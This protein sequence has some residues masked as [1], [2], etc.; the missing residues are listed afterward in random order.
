MK[1]LLQTLSLVIWYCLGLNPQEAKA[2]NILGGE[3]SWKY[4]SNDTFEI[5]VIVYCDDANSNIS[6]ELPG[7]SADSCPSSHIIIPDSALE[8][9]VKML[10]PIC[11]SSNWSY[12]QSLYYSSG[13]FQ[14]IQ[15][16]FRYKVY[17]HNSTNCCWYKIQWTGGT[18][19][20]S[21]TGFSNTPYS[22]DAWLNSCIKN[23]HSPEIRNLPDIF[24]AKNKTVMYS[25]EALDLDG[26]SLSY[27]LATPNGGSYTSPY[28][29]KYPLSCVGGN[30]PSVSPSVSGFNLDSI[31]GFLVF[32][33]NNS[34][35]SLYKVMISEWRKDSAGIYHIIGK[36][37]REMALVVTNFSINQVPQVNAS[38]TSFETCAGSEIC[39][40]IWTID[41]VSDQTYIKW[42]MGNTN[43]SWKGIWNDGFPNRVAGWLCWTPD[44]KD[45]RALPYYFTGTVSDNHCYIGAMSAKNFSIKVNP[46]IKFFTKA[47]CI[48]PGKYKL[49]LWSDTLNGF[50]ASNIKFYSPSV[51]GKPLS[52]RIVYTVSNRNSAE[53][54]Y[55]IGE[56]GKYVL[57]SIASFGNCTYTFL[58]TVCLIDKPELSRINGDYFS[59]S[60]SDCIRDQNESGIAN[61]LI[62][63]EPYTQTVFTDSNGSFRVF[64]DS[65]DYLLKAQLPEYLNKI[66][67]NSVC[68]ASGLYHIMLDNK[69]VD[70]N[71]NNFAENLVKVPILYIDFNAGL[72]RPCNEVTGLLEYGNMGTKD[73][74]NVRMMLIIPQNVHFVNSSTA[75]ER[76]GDTLFF[77]ADTLKAGKKTVIKITMTIDCNGNLLGQY[78]CFRYAISPD[79]QR[80]DTYKMNK[81]YDFSNIKTDAECTSSYL[82]FTIKNTGEA[83]N[84]S[85][86]FRL[87]HNN[88]ISYQ[89]KFLLGK[90]HGKEFFVLPAGGIY[91]LEANQNVYYPSF[92]NPH[93]EIKA[94]DDTLSP[95]TENMNKMESLYEGFTFR[96][97]CYRLVNS[98]DPNNIN[99]VPEGVGPER[100]VMHETRLHYRIDFQ[101][102]GTDTAYEVN[103]ID[104]LPASFDIST[105]MPGGSSHHYSTEITGKNRNVI[106]FSFKKIFLVDSNT[107]ERDSHGF[108]TFSIMPFTNLPSGT[109]I[110]NVASIF[111]DSNDPV[112]TNTVFISIADS[113]S[114]AADFPIA[115]L[116]A[117]EIRLDSIRSYCASEIP[118]DLN[119]GSKLDKKYISQADGK[120]FI[121]DKPISGSIFDPASLG[122]V[123]GSLIVA[124][125]KAKYVYRYLG[126]E[127]SDSTWFVVKSAPLLKLKIP[128]H[129]FLP[130]DTTNLEMGVMGMALSALDEYSFF[131]DGQKTDSIFK[132]SSYNSGWHMI[133][134]NYKAGNCRSTVSDSFFIEVMPRLS[135]ENLNDLCILK[136]QTE[137]FELRAHINSPYKGHWTGYSGHFTNGS[138]DS[139]EHAFYIPGEDELKVNKI[140][141]QWESLSSPG[142]NI[143]ARQSQEVIARILPIPA[144]IIAS[145]TAGCYPLAVRFSTDIDPSWILWSFVDTVSGEVENSNQAK[146]VHTF[147]KPGIYSVGCSAAGAS[148]DCGV[149]MGAPFFIHVYPHPEIWFTCSPDSPSFA[150]VHSPVFKL[151]GMNN[152]STV[153]KEW[154]WWFDEPVDYTHPQAIN[155]N[156]EITYTRDTG[157]HT[158]TLRAKTSEGCESEI[159]RKVRVN[160]DPEVFI[161]NAFSPD[162]AGPSAN[163][164]FR[165]VASGIKTFEMKIYNRWGTLVYASDDYPS[166]YWDGSFKGKPAAMDVYICKVV[167][168]GL[169]GKKYEFGETIQLIR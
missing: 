91:R 82:K 41:E 124:E 9:S 86:E 57:R 61:A 129:Y 155:K 103:V 31:T 73:T 136:A 60:N 55:Y 104:T 80:Y 115:I 38:Q 79:N 58:D 135:V 140:K 95:D 12:Y 164:S 167:V 111:F 99:V 102:T 149:I 48:K 29:Y 43:A 121:N 90:Q 143:C 62:S 25:H 34:Q 148:K 44:D 126:S 147:I 49:S 131:I 68:P 33:P 152:S 133:V 146:P 163:E 101:N 30:I 93:S 158:I 52:N 156:A 85:N 142:W 159:K 162:D 6:W 27:A 160:P 70:I 134:L 76:S 107:N 108:V 26:D 138:T 87:F 157:E 77:K 165:V 67:L 100:I 39:I 151:N 113:F 47:Q 123:Q 139:S 89:G 127:Y 119:T 106:R 22:F 51:A 125:V 1:R 153:I 13:Y 141:L 17:I 7:I 4:L 71:A 117:P 54:N 97:K 75:Y 65:G 66:R 18:R 53:L 35:R 10:T 114:Y 168:I 5:K 118:F 69:I 161:P 105:L 46:R 137:G 40:R 145:D 98:Y 32:T 72:M 84:D 56:E 64:L 150:T 2:T 110:E 92:S 19:G 120:W 11:S 45:V 94:C 3:C 96:E 144:K 109:K 128:K 16:T 8:H 112:I 88:K 63:T 166:H 36:V 50:Q 20:N 130:C 24:S 169:D 28:S 78:R 132:P 116:P 37:S 42:D 74:F 23:N 154:N 14:V 15:H 81:G 83:M 59:S 21:S 122:L